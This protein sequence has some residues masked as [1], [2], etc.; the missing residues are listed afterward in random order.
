[1]AKILTPVIIFAILAFFAWRSVASIHTP[2]VKHTVIVLDFSKSV[3]GRCDS[4]AG[5]LVQLVNSPD[6]KAGESVTVFA[7]GDSKT[8]NEPR[9]L[10]A[11]SEIPIQRRVIEG[12]KAVLRERQG[13]VESWREKCTQTAET[14]VTAIYLAVAR[15]LETLRVKGCGAAAPCQLWVIT[16]A[17]ENME[18]SLT[19]ILSAK[20]KTKP[21][22]PSSKLDNAG[23]TVNFCGLSETLGVDNDTGTKSRKTKR[24]LTPDRASARTEQ[25]RAA[26]QSA[27]SDNTSV[28]F[29]PFCPKPKTTNMPAASSAVM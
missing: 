2:A 15:G 23:I 16:D 20:P 6:L 19:Q 1:M 12:S 17:E 18:P 25:L 22:V 28:V 8:A 13:L 5:I 9:L 3:Q 7:S 10:A 24:R 11:Q 27:F 26:W 4:L 21:S 14:E 29:S